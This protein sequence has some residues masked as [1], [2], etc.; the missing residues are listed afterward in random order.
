MQSK[1][2]FFV[3]LTA[4][5]AAIFTAACF[6]PWDGA[7][8]GGDGIITINLGSS[9]PRMAATLD[10]ISS[11]EITLTGPGGTITETFTGGTATFSVSPGTW[12]VSVR[13]VGNRP[14]EYED[15]SSDFSSETMLRAIGETEVVIKA[16]EHTS[17]TI[18]MFPATEVETGNQL[19]LAVYLANEEGKKEY[20]VITESFSI[21][22]WTIP[23]NKND[24]F[25]RNIVLRAE[26]DVILHRGNFNNTYDILDYSLLLFS[27]DDGCTL[28]IGG[29]GK[30]TI[31][32]NGDNGTKEGA[33]I[34]VTGTLNIHDGVTLKGGNSHDGGGVYVGGGGIVNMYGGTIS[35]NTASN[36]GGGVFVDIGGTFNMYGGL[37][38]D[39]NAEA[40][41]G[42]V[43]VNGGSFPITGGM[44]GEFG[45]IVGNVRG[46]S[47]R[48]TGGIIKGN[49][50]GSG[51]GVYLL[52]SMFTKTGGTIYGYET[53]DK[54]S[55]EATQGEGHAV[56]ADYL[57]NDKKVI[58][59]RD[60]TAGPG[61]NLI[62]NGVNDDD[63]G[64]GS[65]YNLITI[66]SYDISY[67][68][69]GAITPIADT[70]SG[71]YSELT[72]TVTVTVTG[73]AKNTDATAFDLTINQVAGLTITPDSEIDGVTK[74][75]TIEVEYDGSE[76]FSSG[77]AT[78][79]ITPEKSTLPEGYAYDE[80]PTT[81]RIRIADGQGPDQ[82]MIPVHRG[83]ITQF[84]AYAAPPPAT[85][86]D[87]HYKLIEDIELESP[88][89]A[90]NWTPIGN[91]TYPFTG[92]FDGGGNKITGLDIS[93][94]YETNVGLFGCINGTVRNLRVEGSVEGNENV[95]GVVGK[96]GL[97]DGNPVTSTVSGCS[98]T[99]TVS[100]T[101]NVGGIVGYTG[102]DDSGDFSI[103]GCSFTGTVN[104]TTN[105][106]GIVGRNYYQGTVSNC[107][108]TGSVNGDE[109]VGGVVGRNQST[110]FT[111]YSTGNVESN[112]NYIG[113]VLGGNS[114]VVRNCVALNENVSTTST[115]STINIGRVVGNSSGE[116][117]TL[118]NNYARNDMQDGNDAFTADS[119]L[120]GIDGETVFDSDYN[121]QSWWDNP[122]NWD[123]PNYYRWNFDTVWGWDKTTN[124]PILQWQLNEQGKE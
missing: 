62:I 61:V 85:G 87:K 50:A 33:L 7:G 65:K 52:N 8:A 86:L 102:S 49:T 81:I 103:S 14:E 116:S 34:N 2:T 73:F 29:A 83:N 47:F 120:N 22:E 115:S 25:A 4:C 101:T 23:I 10:E 96:N 94:Q 28:T 80:E 108:S 124:L 75:F 91:A 99:G 1:T 9:T 95:G 26:K 37:I 67:R 122:D 16:G 57:T 76:E 24:D 11:H 42:G 97:S 104:G 113:G 105:V 117:A 48:M 68:L 92:T 56:Y 3:L 6:S 106:G 27:V 12:S 45:V 17:T 53:E 77:F 109:Y 43:Y 54:N 21:E 39:N 123:Q 63:W 119:Q 111:C 20:I 121:N 60:E 41:G 64:G 38:S 110:V 69:G 71:G 72:A 89:G 13:A 44:T 98:F 70:T 107:F 58:K 55:N 51:G 114:G 15:Y 112:T 30:G 82:R 93:H 88:T 66:S 79:A 32:I 90:D 19:S 59:Y 35:D 5:I 118:S 31:T 100:G 18:D 84:N 46:P 74:T 78:I 40:G 36:T